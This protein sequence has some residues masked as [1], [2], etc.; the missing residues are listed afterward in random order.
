MNQTPVGVFDS[1]IGG[2]TILEALR[3]WAPGY[4]YLYLGDNARTPYGTRSFETILQFTREAVDYLFRQGCPVIIIACNTASA[5]ALRTLQQTYLPGHYP[6][7]RI[8]GILRP[9]VEELPKRCRTAAIW[10]TPGTIQSNSYAIELEKQ[11][12]SLQWVQQACPLLVPLV[13]NGEWDN[14]GSAYFVKK[15]WNETLSKNP[16]VDG[17]LLACTHYPFLMPTF[18]RVIPPEIPVF[19]QGE[20]VGPRWKDYLERHPEIASQITAQNKVRF[21]TTESTASFEQLAKTLAG[22]DLSSEKVSLSAN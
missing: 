5:K 3:E 18:R 16:A 8:L 11:D 4:D 10:G 19:N 1:G 13:E 22:K 15:Y 12:A 20:F 21:L 2:L 17:L 9:A 6:H 7:R 14:E